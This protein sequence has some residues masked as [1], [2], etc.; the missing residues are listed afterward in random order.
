MNR[1]CSDG[2]GNQLKELIK[3]KGF[4]LKMGRAT[5]D[6]RKILMLYHQGSDRPVWVAHTAAECSLNPW[7]RARTEFRATWSS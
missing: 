1:A 5:L 6:T 7:Q 3:S 4:K 2:N